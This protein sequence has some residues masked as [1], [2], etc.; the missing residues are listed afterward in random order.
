VLSVG[1]YFLLLVPM[2]FALSIWVVAV[3]W[4]SNHPHIRHVGEA[5]AR[6][7]TGRLFR[8]EAVLRRDAEAIDTRYAIATATR[9]DLGQRRPAADG[10]TAAGLPL[11][12]QR[13]GADPVTR[14][15]T[16]ARLAFRNRV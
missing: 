9:F 16:Q 2:V 6:D 10:Y 15:R 8:A 5:L 14:D 3:L 1:D 13:D 7:V 4:T 12:R 11:P